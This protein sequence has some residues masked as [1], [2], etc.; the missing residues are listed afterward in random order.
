MSKPLSVLTGGLPRLDAG[1]LL[2]DR[3]VALVLP[4]KDLTPADVSA[5]GARDVLIMARGGPETGVRHEPGSG[6]GHALIG[7]ASPRSVYASNCTV[8]ILH[9]PA[10]QAAMDPKALARLDTILVPRD[11]TL[12][13]SLPA[14][15]RHARRGRIAIR[16][17]TEIAGRTYIVLDCP[18]AP[19]DNRRQFGPAGVPPVEF[20]RRLDGLSH[21]VLRWPEAIEDGTH[22]GDID[23]LLSA[24]DAPR[25]AQIFSDR[26]ATYPLDIYAE[27]GSGGFYFGRAPYYTPSMARRMLAS[28]HTRPS[29]LHVASDDWR[30]LS[31]AYHLMLH[32]KSRRVPPGTTAL[33]P[34]TFRDP[35]YYAELQ[36]LAAAAG[37]SPPRTFDDI[38]AALRN[39][40]A[41][42][43]IDLLGFYAEK[44]KF[45]K[46]RY[47]DVARYD[48]GLLTLFL[49]DFGAAMEPVPAIR[50]LLASRFKILAEG[51]VDDTNRTAITNGVRGGNWSDATAPGGE[52][53][54]VYWFV[55]HDPN[56]KRPGR[57]TRKKR[58]R[59]DNENLNFKHEIRDRVGVRAVKEQ[60]IIHTSD[61]T[62]EALE[63]I[64]LLGLAD[65][66]NIAAIRLR[67][68]RT[69]A[70]ANG[71]S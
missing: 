40:D 56:P 36:R 42:P 1:A 66:P 16:G 11:W 64:E 57:R 12:A 30:F 61:N 27:D 52:A 37:A 49:R 8:A 24:A 9:G 29:G 67:L 62:G 71:T 70:N 19:I 60:R 13:M 34:K 35:K 26:V 41:F 45:L 43:N 2:R 10:A 47:F 48:A 18:Q 22:D 23:L 31:F 68:T 6:P 5:L 38:E 15:M 7:Y 55:C 3:L 33:S 58:P 17:R 54:P 46:H 21:A 69:P 65:D 50:D 14:M 63:H 53:R 25:V 59:F 4:P 28:V 32:I 44:N 20:L 51:A 39:A